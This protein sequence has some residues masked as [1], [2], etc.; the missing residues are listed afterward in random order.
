[1][2]IASAHEGSFERKRLTVGDYERV[3]AIMTQD[4]RRSFVEVDGDKL[5]TADH[6]TAARLAAAREVD[7][8]SYWSDPS[9]P[10]WGRRHFVYLVADRAGVRYFG[11][12]DTPEVMTICERLGDY[13]GDSATHTPTAVSASW[14]DG[15]FR[16]LHPSTWRP[17][18]HR[19][20]AWAVLTALGVV[21]FLV[22]FLLGRA[23]VDTNAMPVIVPSPAPVDAPQSP[24]Q[25]PTTMPVQS[26]A[27]PPNSDDSHRQ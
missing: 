26:E 9:K 2:D 21:L 12:S 13:L 25:P 11:D 8:S 6:L 7:V 20:P 4:G 5:D 17:P 16:R 10:H 18:Y 27:N 23:S 1:M 19:T 14:F 24:D 22:A 3:V 15:P